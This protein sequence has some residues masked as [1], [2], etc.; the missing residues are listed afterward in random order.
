MTSNV[1]TV[2]AAQKFSPRVMELRKKIHDTEYLDYAIQRIATYLS[3]K[4]VGEEE[5]PSGS[6]DEQ[7]K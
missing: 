7:T 6:A 3:K 5:Y 1:K 4:L 2:F